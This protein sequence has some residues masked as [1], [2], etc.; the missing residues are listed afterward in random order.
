MNQLNRQVIYE[1]DIAWKSQDAECNELDREQIFQFDQRTLGRFLNILGLDEERLENEY[2]VLPRPPLVDTTRQLPRIAAVAHAPVVY[3]GEAIEKLRLEC[4]QAEALALNSEERD[5][6]SS[7]KAASQKALQYGGVIIVYVYAC[8][9]PQSNLRLSYVIEAGTPIEGS[10]QEVLAQFDESALGSLWDDLGVSKE[11][12]Q[13]W[14]RELQSGRYTPV[15]AELPE[16]SVL[17]S[18]DEGRISYRGDSVRALSAECERALQRVHSKEATELLKGLL[19]A[20]AQII[21]SGG[22]IDVHPFGFQEN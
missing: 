4:E 19:G 15:V 8:P 11:R 21:Q 5:M 13:Q 12:W 2:K 6:V 20:C 18:V 16:I 22:E 3:A 7:L 1:I 9:P 17:A 14:D 10:N